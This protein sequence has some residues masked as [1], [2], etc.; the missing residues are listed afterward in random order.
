MA[1]KKLPFVMVEWNDAWIDGNDPVSLGEVKVEHKPK[2]IETWGRLLHDDEVGVSIA[3]ERYK[4]ED[5][6]RGRTFIPRAMIISVTKV[7]VSKVR[8][9]TSPRP[10]PEPAGDADSSAAS[11]S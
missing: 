1:S 5:V 8:A 2:V 6:Y 4:D 9:K 7:N 3:N 10:A 11:E